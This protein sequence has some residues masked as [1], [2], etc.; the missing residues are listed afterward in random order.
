[1]TTAIM[2]SQVTYQFNVT[3]NVNINADR[4]LFLLMAFVAFFVWKIQ[5]AKFELGLIWSDI[6]EAIGFAAK[7]F[8]IGFKSLTFGFVGVQL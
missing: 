4:T 1:M 8:A 6:T 5:H 3:V 7:V 2:Q